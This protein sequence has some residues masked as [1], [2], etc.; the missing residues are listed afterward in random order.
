MAKAIRV[1]YIGAEASRINERVIHSQWTRYLGEYV[2]LVKI[3]PFSMLKCFGGSIEK[4]SDQ[5][6]QSLPA[7]AER[8]ADLSRR[9]ELQAL[10]MN[11]TDIVPY[12]L[13]A[14]NE[15]R[16]DLG[17]V[18]IAH[19]VGSEHWLKQ[20]V[21]I[22]PWLTGK[23]VLLTSTETSK[24]A[25]LNVS[26]RFGQAHHIPLCIDV[27]QRAD[28]VS[29]K[30]AGQRGKTIFSIGRLEDVKNIDQLL[31]CYAQI[32]QHVPDC[33]L[34]IAGEYTGFSAQ[35][36]E[37]YRQT[38]QS[39]LAELDLQQSVIFTGPVQGQLKEALFQQADILL[40]LSTDP[41]ETFGFNLIE[42]KTWG[43]PVVCT[44][45]DG[46]AELVQHGT[47]GYL[48]DCHWQEAMP[49]LNRE[50][51]VEYSVRL[52][53][54][55][56]LR[57]QMSGQAQDRAA[58]F[59]YRQIMPRIVD[60]ILQ[61]IDVPAEEAGRLT[62]PVVQTACTPIRDLSAIY[63]RHVLTH[64]DLCSAT[65]FSILKR[66]SPTPLQSWMSQCKPFIS[67]YA[68]RFADEQYQTI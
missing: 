8:L 38:I 54:D 20:W 26:H 44:H 22:A 46:F 53:E 16:L 45:W 9:Y 67:H 32:R 33:T 23:D 11:W 15:A 18:L 55:H 7:L 4:W 49:Q 42:A 66:T 6:P 36:I 29:G 50:Q 39:I 3:P 5:F 51:V 62:E 2:Q 35:Q 63:T 43:V 1:G 68:G 37:A 41:G 47:D 56:Q 31:L 10:Y 34:M 61:A 40:N 28:K 17:F 30:K 27:P 12:L 65:P 24:R 60:A 19:C 58:R 14:R 25:L 52:L 48:V 21:A 64:S 57:W 13:L 59:D